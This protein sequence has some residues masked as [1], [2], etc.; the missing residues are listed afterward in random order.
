MCAF[1]R[2][3][4]DIGVGASASQDQHETSSADGTGG[5]ANFAIIA[6]SLQ[7]FGG[8]LAHLQRYHSRGDRATDDESMGALEYIFGTLRYII[9]SHH[10]CERGSVRVRVRVRAR[11]RVRVS[12][13]CERSEKFLVRRQV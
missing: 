1:T 13:V 6:E 4:A 12:H 9:R 8:A 2:A 3:A 11:A 7:A 5:G 10:A